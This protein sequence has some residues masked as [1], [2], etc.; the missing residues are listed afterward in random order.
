VGWSAEK[1]QFLLGYQKT[2][3]GRNTDGID[4]I[5]LTAIC[6]LF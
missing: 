1:I 4:S 6:P 3:Y 5:A 2:V